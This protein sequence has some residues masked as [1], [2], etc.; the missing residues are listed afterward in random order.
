[1]PRGPEDRAD[2]R[3]GERDRSVKK[4]SFPLRQEVQ[5]VEASPHIVSVSD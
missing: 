2:T 4:L 5:E 3:S 1:M